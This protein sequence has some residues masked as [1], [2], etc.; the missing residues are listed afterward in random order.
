MKKSLPPLILFFSLFVVNLHAQLEPFFKTTIHFEDAIGNRDS[1]VFGYDIAATPDM[2]EAYGEEEII[3]SFDAVFE[4]RAGS[5]FN[6]K[7]TKY[8]ITGTEGIGDPNCYSGGECYVYIH[9]LHQ[10]IKVWWDKE[11]LL[12]EECQQG[13]WIV[14][15]IFDGLAGPI[16]MDEIP[17][18][19]YCMA[20]VDTGYFEVTVDGI[21]D[22]A[23]AWATV[24]I[25][26]EVEGIGLTT[27]YGLRLILTPWW[28]YTPCFWITDVLEGASYEHLELYPNPASSTVFFNY[29]D[30]LNISS[31]AIYSADGQRLLEQE[32]V[33]EINVSEFAPALYYIIAYT[34]IGNK[35]VGRFIKN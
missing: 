10:P 27:I 15:H 23:I 29:P 16:P 24:D 2:D 7:L 6:N 1:I 19:Y 4:A 22:P 35:L 33:S 30:E 9:A 32:A 26:K 13:S 21:E 34:D 18:L 3:T 5:I 11:E 28:G 12:A 8:L 14:N 25:E 31:V 20:D 17:P